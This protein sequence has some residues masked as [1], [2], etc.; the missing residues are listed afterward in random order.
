MT[1]MLIPGLDADTKVPT[2]TLEMTQQLRIGKATIR[3]QH[4]L[5]RKRYQ[6]VGLIQ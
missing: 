5:A 3:Q 1:A 4:H 6:R 2:Q